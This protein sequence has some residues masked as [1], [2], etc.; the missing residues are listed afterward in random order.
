[1]MK[2]QYLEVGKV[3]GT[4]GIQGEMRVQPWSDSPDFLAGFRTFFLDGAGSEKISVCSVRPHGNL[5]LVKAEGVDSIEGAERFRGRV[6]FINRDDIALEEGRHFVEDLLGCTVLDADSG[7]VLGQIS[8]VSA[9]GAN[10]VWHISRGGKEYLIPVIPE[11]VLSVDT[12][13]EEV[14]IRPLKGIFDDE[15]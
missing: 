12:D 8:D 11:V 1:M 10:D 13:R 7:K 2:K 4:H 3:V 9:T 5:V 14:V 6:L 15:D